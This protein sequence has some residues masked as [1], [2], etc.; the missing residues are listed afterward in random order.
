MYC[1]KCGSPIPDDSRFCNYCG[2]SVSPVVQQPT[3][4]Q[5]PMANQQA[6]QNP[7][8]NQQAPQNPM[9][10]QQVPQNPMA[11]QQVPQ[12]SMA[13]QQ[14]PQNPM[15][16]QQV[17]QSQFF[18]Q[19]NPQPPVP[20][21]KKKKTGLII[22]ILVLVVLL[23]AGAMFLLN[24]DKKDAA[25]NGVENPEE[26]VTKLYD[27]A[28]QCDA[29]LMLS[30][31]P[32]A[33]QD[34]L[35]EKDDLDNNSLKKAVQDGLN[36]NLDDWKDSYGNNIEIEITLDHANAMPKSDIDDMNNK[37]DLVTIEAGYEYEVTVTY[38]GD[39]DSDTISS[40]QTALKIDGKWY[41]LDAMGVLS[42]MVE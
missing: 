6:P 8:A 7:M 41:S 31:V 28:E 29:D 32:K 21:K 36:D 11:N 5:S 12:N 38:K 13:N 9:A 17:P 2:T 1:K 16:N 24:R 39:D 10:N 30:L 37:N 19:A 35:M 40:I 33:Y 18:Q 15:A 3:V 42:A 20:K 4:P 23:A 25:S 14:V 22:L 27:A 34:D 26:A